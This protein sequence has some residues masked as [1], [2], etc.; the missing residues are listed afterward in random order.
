MS[1]AATLA[2][3]AVLL[4]GL[5]L[6]FGS[7]GN[8]VIARVPEGRS[9]VRPRSACPSCGTQIL[10]RDNIPVISWLLLR[11]RCRACG[12]HISARYPLVELTAG[13]LFV[14][15]GWWAW[16]ADR[17][18][19]LPLLLAWGLVGLCLAM[20]DVDHH[21]LPDALTLPMLAVT[22]AGLLLA[23]LLGDP[24]SW[25]AAAWGVVIWLGVVGGLWALSRGRGMGLGDVKLAPSL[26][27]LLGWISL[28][29]AVVGL[30]AAFI[31]GALVGIAL[32]IAHR[33]GRGSRIAFGPFLLLGTLIGV[34]VGEP[35]AAAYWGGVVG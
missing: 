20:I 8:V 13:I 11:A 26:G 27:A 30:L 18:G 28:G 17:L 23:Q 16:Q 4:F 10:G 9:V 1:D 32:M 24:G 19:L 21:R 2:F 7:F 3:A 25:L 6:I 22:A 33:A 14:A 12:A 31:V 5:G 35:I 34:L 29:S 15:L